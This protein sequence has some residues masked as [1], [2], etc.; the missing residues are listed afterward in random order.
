M[1][2]L[3]AENQMFLLMESTVCCRLYNRSQ[4]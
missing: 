4:A 3:A 1:A 2:F